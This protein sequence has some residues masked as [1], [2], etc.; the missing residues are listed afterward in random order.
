MESK[1]RDSG[2]ELL[3]ILALLLTFWMHGAS[4]YSNNEL[5]A[6][7]CIVIETVGNIGVTLFI[8][9]SGYFSVKLKPIKMIQLDMMIVFYCWVWR[10]GSSGVRRRR[11][12]GNRFCLIYFR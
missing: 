6:W 5:S 7:L 2:L 9:I 4:S 3:R 8:L 1:T 11:T 10:C 12:V